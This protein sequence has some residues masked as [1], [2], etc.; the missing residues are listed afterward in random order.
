MTIT[1]PSCGIHLRI[2]DEHAGKMLKCPKCESQ[3]QA[4]AAGQPMQST[5]ASDQLPSTASVTP[6]G[7]GHASGLPQ[8]APPKSKA[9]VIIGVV[10]IL[11][12]LGILGAVFSGGETDP[13]SASDEEIIRAA[14]GE[15]ELDYFRRLKDA[16]YAA[17]QRSL[18]SLRGSIIMSGLTCEEYAQRKAMNKMVEEKMD[19]WW[20]T[21]RVEIAAKETQFREEHRN[22]IAAAR[23]EW[24]QAC[25][26][27]ES[28]RLTRLSGDEYQRRKAQYDAALAREQATGKTYNDLARAGTP[29]I[30][31]LRDEYD[32]RAKAYRESLL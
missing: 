29:E 23:L 9:P 5:G 31:Q 27:R 12:I 16:D 2:S 4:P 21:A 7:A 30:Y 18:K 13:K 20:K 26:A 10:A 11:V 3:F 28:I 24:T 22:R 32:A 1:C 17:Y 8:G 15:G 6:A 19:E 14:V 25:R